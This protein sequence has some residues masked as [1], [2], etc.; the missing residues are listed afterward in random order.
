MA[1][2]LDFFVGY[3]SIASLFGG[4][5]QSSYAAGNAF[6]DALAHLRRRAGQPGMSIN[7]GGFSER[8]LAARRK[9]NERF[10][11]R[12]MEPISPAEGKKLLG[13]LLSAPRVQ[14][15]VVKLEPA[16]WVKHY[17]SRPSAAYLSELLPPSAALD[18]APPGALRRKL[19][20]APP[21]ERLALLIE[22]LREHASLVL[23]A[24]AARLGPEV[25]FTQLGMDSLMAIELRD[26]LIFDLQVT[27][28]LT[29]LVRESGITE[30]ADYIL[31]QLPAP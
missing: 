13:E 19:L 27:V 9:L 1:Q 6:V 23:R 8:G 30:L 5:G 26:R 29:L 12:G 2:P 20:A 28:P 7:W 10:T 15:A 16:V 18:R 17:H 11:G 4:P 24:P 25:P 22:G 14:V 3:S 21:A 31:T